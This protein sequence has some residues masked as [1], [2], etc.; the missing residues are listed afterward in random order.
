MG[1]DWIPEEILAMEPVWRNF[2]ENTATVQFDHRIL[3]MSTAAAIA[4]TYGVARRNPLVWAVLPSSSRS[5]LTATVG[6][7]GA[8]VREDD[9]DNDVKVGEQNEWVTD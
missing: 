5:A 3:A 9:E 7:A 6:M 2:F 8:Q 4:A 1:D